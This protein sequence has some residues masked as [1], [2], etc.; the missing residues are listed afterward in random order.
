MTPNKA[1]SDRILAYDRTGKFSQ[2][3]LDYMNA[4]QLA[5]DPKHVGVMCSTNGL[6]ATQPLVDTAMRLAPLKYTSHSIPQSGELRKRLKSL[7][8]TPKKETVTSVM[9][10]GRRAFHLQWDRTFAR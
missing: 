7:A 6:R 10:P 3:M 2:A 5:S 8:S 4:I 9:R 1:Y